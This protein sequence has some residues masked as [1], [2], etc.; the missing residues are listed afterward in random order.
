MLGHFSC[1][2]VFA[3]LWTVA[4]GARLLCPWAPPSKN[5]GVACHV[6]FQGIFPTQGS[7]LC[8]LHFLH[9]QAGSL[10]LAPPGK[11][12]L[13]YTHRCKYC[14]K[15]FSFLSHFS[16]SVVLAIISM[17]SNSN[18]IPMTTTSTPQFPICLL[19]P[20]SFLLGRASLSS[21]S[22]RTAS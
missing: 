9:W 22:H 4:K 18:Y 3:T 13:D 19:S 17:N 6:L 5:A 7:N 14:Y 1:V 21:R 10:P 2:W 16:C 12:L 15:Y 20:T 11:P 8:L